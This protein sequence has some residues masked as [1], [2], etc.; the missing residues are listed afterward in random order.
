MVAMSS[1]EDSS[2]RG[3]LAS[4]IEHVVSRE[5]S[6]LLREADSSLRGGANR[7][8]Y[9]AV[10]LAC[11]ESI[12]RKFKMLSSGD[13]EAGKIVGELA[14]KENLQQ[15]VDKYLLVQAKVYG[16][17]SESEHV[18]LEHIY[19][20]RCIYGHPYEQRPTT[21]VVIAAASEIV[22]M[23][24]SRPALLRHAYLNRQ[25]ESVFTDVSFLGDDEADVDEFADLVHRRSDP[26]LQLWFAKKLIERLSSTRSSMPHSAL[27]RRPT[28]FTQGF[29]RRSLP[30][31]LSDWNLVEELG[32]YRDAV[33]DVMVHPD[34]FGALEDHPR[35]II[36]RTICEDKSRV[37]ALRRLRMLYDAGLLTSGL[38]SNYQAAIETAGAA[39]VQSAGFP[40]DIVVP[41]IV[42]E[43]KSHNWYLQNPAVNALRN[44]GP[45]A[46]AGLPSDTQIDLGRNLLQAADGD[47][48][49]AK[50]FI[51]SLAEPGSLWTSHV[52]E[53][54]VAECFVNE[55]G[56]LRFKGEA[57]VTA[58]RSLDNV[59]EDERDAIVRR[60][61]AAIRAGTPKPHFNHA[62]ARDQVV[63]VIQNL[64][65]YIEPVRLALRT[66][67]LPCV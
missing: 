59:P 62:A 8:A 56:Q 22:R 9:I 60:L 20:M 49:E 18:A 66:L 48:D 26:T 4:Y 1:V 67:Q 63:Q 5:D 55:R 32:K 38:G 42:S 51:A 16:L 24:L 12:K 45:N 11:A 61:A 43:L 3:S 46:V 33:V 14:R 65:E 64:P 13:T 36:V 34:I 53:G 44:V 58:L 27:E 29:I 57:L 37:R 6:V 23:V 41:K 19:S 28:W 10:W 52:I 35:G 31:I 40:V 2:S 7:M 54:I 21:E 25:M 15:S 17:I 30:S 47:A 50:A 39:A